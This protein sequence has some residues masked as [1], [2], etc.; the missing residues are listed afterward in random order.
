MISSVKAFRFRFYFVEKF[1]KL[2]LFAFK[3]LLNIN[4]FALDKKLVCF[5]IKIYAKLFIL[6]NR[7]VNNSDSRI[8]AAF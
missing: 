8:L 7:T 5:G 2:F 4:R 1:L 6:C 3:K